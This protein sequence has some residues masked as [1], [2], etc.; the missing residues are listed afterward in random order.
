M[1]MV[2]PIF[3]IVLILKS[4]VLPIPV[5]SVVHRCYSFGQTDITD[6]VYIYVRVTSILFVTLTSTSVHDLNPPIPEKWL[7]QFYL[8][9]IKAF[10]TTFKGWWNLVL[11]WKLFQVS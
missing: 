6:I 1:G 2:E 9:G 5:V 3:Y 10:T 7:F 11:H 4:E 8:R